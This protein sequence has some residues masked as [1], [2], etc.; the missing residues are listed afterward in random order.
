MRIERRRSGARG[1]RDRMFMGAGCSGADS[2][3]TRWALLVACS[4]LLACP[5]DPTQTPD[6]SEVGSESM[7]TTMG[8]GTTGATEGVDGDGTASTGDTGGTTEPSDTTDAT[9]TTMPDMGVDPNDQ[10]PPP[11]EEGCHA[12]Y[13]Q[14][15]LPTFEVTIAP[16]HWEL[17][18]WEW[19]NGMANEAA[20]LEYNPYHPLEEFR[21]GDVVIHDAH[22]R[23]KGNPEFWEPLPL[24]KMQFQIGFH[25][26]DPDGRF[27]GLKRLGLDAATFNRHM[28]R[29]RLSLRFMRDVGIV[30][31]CANNA[32]LMVNGEYYG[33]FTNIEKLDEVF[34]ERT[35]EDPSGALWQRTNWEHE[36]G[37]DDETRLELLRDMDEP[38]ELAELEQ[39]M[40][41]E[42]ALLTYAAEAVIPD[43][44]G[45]WAGGLNFFLYDDPTR[46][47]FMLLPWDLDNTF[48]RFEDE[49]DGAYPVNP[50]PVVWE[51]ANTHGRPWYDIALQDPAYFDYY[52]DTIDQILHEGYEPTKMLGWIDEMSAQIEEAVITDM[53]KPYPNTTY[54]NRLEDLREYVQVRYDFVDGW[55]VCWQTGG[56]ADPEGYCVPP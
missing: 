38:E 53:N 6:G 22:I 35:M 27:W 16:E 1:V 36:S 52:I 28:L 30:A 37:S 12:I 44:D 49:P 24:D 45:A 41:I 25:V 31:P 13:A 32:R 34:L 47:K 9:T 43:S 29:D 20:D 14:D 17:L 56:T 7:G 50:D 3:R 46:G 23:L 33:V 2:K 40:D 55:L 39:L 15:L 54:Y 8:G 10:I 42:Q 5:S 11:D 21:Y 4:T 48:E 19:N 51:K 26:E 18:M